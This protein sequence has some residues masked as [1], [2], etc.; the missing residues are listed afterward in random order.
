[1][2]KILVYLFIAAFSVSLFYAFYSQILPA[3]DAKAYDAIAWNLAEGFG[4]RENRNLSYEGDYALGRAGPGYEFFLAGVYTIFGHRYWPVWILQSLFHIISG[5]FIFLIYRLLLAKSSYD[6]NFAT[7]KVISWEWEE[8]IDWPVVVG[9]S[10]F[11]F[12]PDLIQINGML[13]TESLFIF[14]IS[15]SVFLGLRIL[16]SPS[17]GFTQSI[18]LA[19]LV[20]FAVLVRPGALLLFL[21]F[22]GI[23][24]YKKRW[25][26]FLIMFG[27]LL[28]IVGPWAARNYFRHGVLFTNATGGLELWVSILPESSGE[29]QMNK[30]V[31]DY[32]EKNGLFKIAERGKEEFKKFIFEHPLR[33]ILRQLE[34]TS[35]YFSM[36]RTSGF[37][38]YLSGWKQLAAIFF[39]AVFNALLFA[40]GL[41]GAYLI[42]KERKFL[43]NAFL[44]LA[45]AM[46][47][48]VI[49][50][51]V[52]GRY[53]YPLL[54]FLAASALY[55]LRFI[56]ENK[57]LP[58]IFWVASSALLVNGGLDIFFN[59]DKFI[60]HIR[61]LGLDI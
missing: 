38:L 8:K 32:L 5:I 24:L 36:I 12:H 22:S 58:K 57:R 13:M 45:A 15:A 1:M 39:S 9:L 41:A 56:R 7:A 51:V 29:F 49:P 50:I 43:N 17:P 16:M 61:I 26:T 2:N 34:K 4:Y 21:V 23:F 60:S 53:R 55:F 18:I 31:S 6:I 33:F 14:L 48:S 19:L 28:L 37:W 47:L 30:E 11:L 3:V 40:L 27:I 25:K 46:P 44:L 52:T 42:F 10:L 35:I 20:A 59:F 54:I